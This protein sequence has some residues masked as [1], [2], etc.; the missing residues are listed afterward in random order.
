MPSKKKTTKKAEQ[1]GVTFLNGKW[2]TCDGL[3]FN[4]ADKA[5]KHVDELNLKNGKNE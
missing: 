5:W 4:T 3:C 2:V 1:P